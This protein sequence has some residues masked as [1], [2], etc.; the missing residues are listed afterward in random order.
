M[1]LSEIPRIPISVLV[2]AGLAVLGVY[3]F[4]TAP[5]RL[6]DTSGAGR[7]ISA[8]TLLRLLDAENAAT[9]ALYASEIVGPGQKAGLKFRED[10]RSA[11]VHAGPLPALLLRETASRL[12]ARVPDLSLFLGSNYPIEVSNNFSGTQLGYFQAIER[13]GKPQFFRDASTGRHTAMFADLAS[14]PSCVTCHNEHPKSPRTDWK[15]NDL[16]GATTWAF[17]RDSVS[18]EEALAMLAA[19]RAAALDSYS[20]YLKKIDAFPVELRPTV[21]EHWPKEGLHL[22]DAATFRAAVEARNSRATLNAL[23]EVSGESQ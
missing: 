2:L 20:A 3:L 11:D 1:N 17:A 13:T 19:Y 22:P 23:L 21:G 12:Q 6:D 16:M 8:E 4:A 9:R 5:A 18:I 15:L 10:W 7:Q 14:A